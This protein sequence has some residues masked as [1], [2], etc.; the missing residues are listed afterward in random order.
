MR[1]EDGMIRP[2]RA[3][4]SCAWQRDKTAS[5]SALMLGPL[6]Q[7]PQSSEELRMIGATK[8][9][10]FRR[11]HCSAKG[12]KKQEWRDAAAPGRSITG[13]GLGLN[14][15]HERTNEGHQ[16]RGLK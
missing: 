2:M 1:F 4:S 11:F 3:L 8:S 15:R 13:L 7:L 10:P 12:D 9:A 6:I 14:A 5:S 16:G